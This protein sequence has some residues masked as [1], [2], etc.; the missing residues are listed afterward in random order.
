M[1]CRASAVGGSI[2]NPSISCAKEDSNFVSP[3]ITFTSRNVPRSWHRCPPVLAF[4][5]SQDLAS[6]GGPL[7]LHCNKLNGASVSPPTQKPPP[8]EAKFSHRVLIQHS[9]SFETHKS[10]VGRLILK[11]RRPTFA[12]GDIDKDTADYQC[13]DCGEGGDP[14]G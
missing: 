14:V 7:T 12:R 6:S 10:R 11:K 4:R 1:N 5:D 2:E 8:S 3:P 13:S 9:P